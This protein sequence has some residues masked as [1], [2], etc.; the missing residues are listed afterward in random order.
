M[1]V[2]TMV[3]PPPEVHDR[4]LRR[5][6]AV[7]FAMCRDRGKHSYIV[8]K[9]RTRAALYWYRGWQSCAAKK[10]AWMRAGGETRF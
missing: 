6:H 8:R 10:R 2:C 9:L 7:D 3:I 5:V 1:R 4:F